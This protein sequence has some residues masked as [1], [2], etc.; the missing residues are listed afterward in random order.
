M[1]VS[2]INH[3]VSLC[4]SLIGLADSIYLT[5][6]KLTNNQTM[7]LKGIG[8][9]WTVNLSSYSEI[10]G[11]PIAILG[12]LAYLVLSILFMLRHKLPVSTV[13]VDQ[14]FFGLS[15]TG[16]IYSIYLTYLEI[17]VIK[18]LCPFCIVSAIAM[19]VI[20]I[21]TLLRLVQNRSDY[22]LSLEEKN[23]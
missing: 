20:F 9:C 15:L 22:T 3:I 8:D 6:L 5:V 16:F 1:K 4:A 10:F 14:M 13:V 7:C 12:I 17:A 2:S 19:T 11:M 23:G 18:A 21:G